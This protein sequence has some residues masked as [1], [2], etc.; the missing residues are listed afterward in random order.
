MRSR[1]DRIAPAIAVR[2][3][4]RPGETKGLLK[5]TRKWLFQNPAY[6]LLYFFQKN[7]GDSPFIPIYASAK[8]N[9]RAPISHGIVQRER[10]QDDALR[11]LKHVIMSAISSSP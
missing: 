7:T 5:N 2:C 4:R 8:L 6:K 1:Y 3:N 9:C 10:S 11:S